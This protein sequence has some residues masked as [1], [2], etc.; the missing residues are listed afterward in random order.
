LNQEQRAQTLR[1]LESELRGELEHFRSLAARNRLR[2]Q[3]ERDRAMIE[4]ERQKRRC[5]ELRAG[6]KS[7]V[8]IAARVDIGIQTLRRWERG[9]PAFSA[10]YHGVYE[11]WKA[12]DDQAVKVLLAGYHPERQSRQIEIRETA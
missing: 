10:A 5:V 12:G 9:D 4:R 8:R 11:R 7:G 3:R 6:G 2:A 1:D